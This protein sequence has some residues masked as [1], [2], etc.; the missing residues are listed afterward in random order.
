MSLLSQSKSLCY[1]CKKVMLHVIVIV[2]MHQGYN[3]QRRYK[4]S[5]KIINFVIIS[6][7]YEGI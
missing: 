4:E 2:K 7:L 3:Y 6:L 1:L 5:I